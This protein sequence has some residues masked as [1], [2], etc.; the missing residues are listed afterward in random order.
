MLTIRNLILLCIISLLSSCF[1]GSGES[2]TTASSSSSSSSG[3]SGS[4]SSSGGSVSSYQTTEYYNQR[5][6]NQISAAE[7]YFYLYQ[8]SKNVAGDGINIAIIDSGTWGSHEAIT[9][10]YSGDSTSLSSVSDDQNHG[11]HV[12]GIAAAA[13]TDDSNSMHGVAFNA[14]IVGMPYYPLSGSGGLYTNQLSSQIISSGSTVINMSYGG[15][16]QDSTH[17]TQIKNVLD[18]PTIGDK[19]VFVAAAGNDRLD[20]YDIWDDD[21]DNPLY[22]A[23]TAI[24]SDV[25][26][27]MIVATSLNTSSYKLN[28][29]ISASDEVTFTSYQSLSGNI[30]STIA[31]YS[32]YCGDTARYCMAAPGGDGVSYSDGT[33]I[34]YDIYSS[35]V[36]NSSSASANIS[37]YDYYA[38]TSMASPT[39]AGAAAVLQSAWPNLSG[40]DVVQILLETSD[41]L[42]CSDLELISLASCSETSISGSTGTYTYNNVTGWGAL[43]LLSAVSANGSADVAT[44]SF[45]GIYY[46]LEASNLNVSKSVASKLISSEIFN[47]AV[48]FDTYQR[49]YNANLADKLVVESNSAQT[50]NFNYKD[51]YKAVNFNGLSFGF[52]NLTDLS[53]QDFVYDQ[54]NSDEFQ[55][56]NLSYNSN[57]GNF[58]L[59][60]NYSSSFQNHNYDENS[61]NLTNE[62][63]DFNQE[64]RFGIQVAKNINKKLNY[65]L[66]FFSDTNNIFEIHNLINLK[67]LKSNINIIYSLVASNENILGMSG[68][69]AFSFGD[70]NL[71]HVL[72]FDYM[73]SVND[74]TKL[75][76]EYR[77]LQ[78]NESNNNLG[79]LRNFRNLA[80]NSMALGVRSKFLNDDVTFSLYYP[81]AY[82]SGAVDIDVAI[83]RD[84]SSVIRAKDTIDLSEEHRQVNYS[85]S[86]DKTINK[87][88]ISLR[89]SF[90]D[91]FNH[92]KDQ[93]DQLLFL[94]FTRAF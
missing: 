30:D 65:K 79:I 11:T 10:N 25:A 73:K 69:E 43:N 13:K 67:V 52:V 48:F 53:E 44:N 24:D 58:S 29:T 77:H 7:A 27:Q 76:F 89:Y 57:Y 38:G 64:D 84:D 75:F 68:T 33:G 87:N 60:F 5:G 8:N 1:G 23:R 21:A 51:I 16:S 20:V 19:A 42:S 47:K 63:F 78:S 56:S 45:G 36:T 82:I 86:Y 12:A 9:D 70:K 37:N 59:A 92:A 66:G 34:D 71:N 88:D 83:G 14:S 41:Y 72:G 81:P 26:G 90:I 46:D 31:Y 94:E 91:N 80:Q 6:L 3:S 28:A 85:L 61:L 54:N 4:S 18:D 17:L 62:I 50:V 74:K 2:A 93:Q 40:A 55:L 35:V 39:I 49:D 15:F 22:P 32:N